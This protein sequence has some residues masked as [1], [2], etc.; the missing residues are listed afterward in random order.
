M[1]GLVSLFESPSYFIKLIDNS[2]S[3]LPLNCKTKM[4]NSYLQV[5]LSIWVEANLVVFLV[6]VHIVEQLGGQDVSLKATLLILNRDYAILRI[7]FNSA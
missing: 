2:G 4:C 5:V 7:K 6:P 1:D 3:L